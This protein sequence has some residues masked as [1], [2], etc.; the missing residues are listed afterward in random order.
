MSTGHQKDQT[1]IRGYELQFHPHPPERG[2]RLKMELE[3]DHVH[4]RKEP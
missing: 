3:I 4:V 2:E 1:I